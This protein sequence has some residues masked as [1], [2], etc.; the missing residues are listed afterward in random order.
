MNLQDKADL[1]GQA[2][3]LYMTGHYTQLEIAAKVGITRRTLFNWIQS[4]SWKRARQNALV[5]PTLI[6]ENLI[7]SVL[8]LQ[9]FIKN[10]P[11]GERFPSPQETITIT[12]LLTCI[13]RMSSYP[14]DALQMQCLAQSN[15]SEET[16]SQQPLPALASYVP[17]N[18]QSPSKNKVDMGN[19]SLQSVDEQELS[20][21]SQVETNGKL[22]LPNVHEEELDY[23]SE[24]ERITRED[25]PPCPENLSPEERKKAIVKWFVNRQLY[26]SGNFNLSNLDGRSERM[27][28]KE[29]WEHFLNHGYSVDDLGYALIH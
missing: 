3:R 2:H 27:V 7:S 25:E 18:A 26:P 21:F 9:T 19:S 24:L 28:T 1:V 23:A 8:E 4:G 20:T 29:E 11:Q 17:Y 16:T 13:T 12:K 22:Y 14:T 15:S 5:A 10:R 6:T